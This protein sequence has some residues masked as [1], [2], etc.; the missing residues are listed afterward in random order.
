MYRQHERMVEHVRVHVCTDSMHRQYVQTVCTDSIMCTC[1]CTCKY[2]LTLPPSRTTCLKAVAMTD[3]AAMLRNTYIH[4]ITLHYIV[5]YVTI[6]MIMMMKC[7]LLCYSMISHVMRRNTYMHTSYNNMI[8]NK[9][10]QN[11][12]KRF[13]QQVISHKKKNIV[14]VEKD[15]CLLGEP[16]PTRHLR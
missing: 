5:T 13:T 15:F 2:L 12:K 10:K 9:I 3:S 4:H 8:S 11:E 14:C 7:S 16:C 1:M 6:M